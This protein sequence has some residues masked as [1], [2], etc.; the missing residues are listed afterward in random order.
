MATLR[1]KFSVGLF[2]IV[3]VVIISVGIIW[4]G[5]SK[6]LEKG[7]FFVAYFDES[8][9]GLDKDSPVKYRGVY[10][11]RVHHVGLAP[12]E[13]LIEV[14][15]KVETDLKPEAL[16]KDVVAQ[17]KSVGIT[18]L[19]FIELEHS[20]DRAQFVY[21]PAGIVPP[22]PVVPTQSSEITKFF[23]GI[24]DLFALFRAID[25]QEISDQLVRT[26]R[27]VNRT[28]DAAQLETMATD[29]RQTLQNTKDLIASDNARQL[30]ASLR[31]A[32]DSFDSAAQNADG[33][34]S[35]IRQ[36]ISRLEDAI[37]N[38][39]DDIQQM[40]ADLKTSARQLKRAMETAAVL[41][42]NTDRKVDTMQRQ[43]LATLMSIEQSSNTL[44]R[45]LDRVA[46][47]PSQIVFSG[48]PPEKPSAP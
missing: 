32:S 12:D 39:D 46:V 30:I 34:I 26:L 16:T 14:V 18:G 31:R 24:D 19:M 37:E 20:E 42:E 27:K 10:I 40:T 2:L 28:I 22:Y 35:E 41:L 23:K 1:T 5:M 36:T 4:L 3:G 8:I 29:L 44:N 47:Q 48:N 15:M 33:G 13:K 43:I 25:T 9:Q 45:F 6:Y 21:P 7:Q 17:L 38:S 11:G